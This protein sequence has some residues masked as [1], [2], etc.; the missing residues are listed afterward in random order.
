[1]NIDINKAAKRGGDELTQSNAYKILREGEAASETLTPHT[2][3]SASLSER[4]QG[5]RVTYPPIVL[6]KEIKNIRETLKTIK[7]WVPSAHFKVINDCHAIMTNNIK[8]YQK[9]MKNLGEVNI[10]FY[11]FT[12]KQEKHKKLVL[13]G[14]HD[15]FTVEDIKQDLQSQ[16]DTIIEVVK[17]KSLR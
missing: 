5:P 15:L 11:T 12:P 2:S 6:Q 10:K 13:K 9:I 8:D 4:V 14:V 3:K 16:S 1:M 7:S 17:M